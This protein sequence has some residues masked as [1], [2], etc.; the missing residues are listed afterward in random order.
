MQ[1]QLFQKLKWKPLYE[2]STN[3]S[4]IEFAALAFAFTILISYI[5]NF[6]KPMLV[7]RR[8]WA[9]NF[10]VDFDKLPDKLLKI[11]NLTS[12]FLPSNS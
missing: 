7:E 9:K 2:I 6:L 12:Q 8:N 10:S 5:F 4:S 1:K 3:R 11:S